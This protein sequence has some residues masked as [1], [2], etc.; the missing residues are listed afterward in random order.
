MALDE[1]L[2]G[3]HR[4]SGP[5]HRSCSMTQ[6]PEPFVLLAPPCSRSYLRLAIE[7]WANRSPVCNWC[8]EFF[9]LSENDKSKSICSALS[10]LL[11]V[12][13]FDCCQ[14]RKIVLINPAPFQSLILKLSI[15]ETNLFSKKL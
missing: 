1:L 10:I 6:V 5:N 2:L 7:T 13:I 11:K 8:L 15:L 12:V 4:K 14:V 3:M 9:K